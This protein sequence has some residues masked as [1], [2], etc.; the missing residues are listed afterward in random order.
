MVRQVHLVPAY[1]FIDKDELNEILDTK[2][3]HCNNSIIQ[4]DSIILIPDTEPD[5][6]G[7]D[8][9]KLKLGNSVIL[10]NANLEFDSYRLLPF[11]DTILKTLL[12]FLSVNPKIKLVISGHTDDIGS[13]EYNLD[14]SINRAKSVYNWL[15]N[16]GIDSTRLAYKGFGKSVPFRYIDR[17]VVS[18]NFTPIEIIL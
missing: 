17:S 13:E 14:L 12:T 3:C 2:E 15:I 16:N 4:K 6:I 8:L 5:I 7:T 9:T 18:I 11:S 1:Y 10:K